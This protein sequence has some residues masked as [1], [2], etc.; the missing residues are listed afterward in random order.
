LSDSRRETKSRNR[1]IDLA[2][3]NGLIRGAIQRRFDLRHVG[4]SARRQKTVRSLHVVADR[5]ERW[6]SSCARVEATSPIAL[7]RDM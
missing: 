1:R 2:S 6:F 3:A 4:V 7:K 5:G